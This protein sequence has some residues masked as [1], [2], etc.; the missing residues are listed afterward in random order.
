MRHFQLRDIEKLYFGYEDI[1]RALGISQNSAK[2]TAHRYVKQ[3]ML[4]RIKRN[5]YILKERWTN[6]DRE[7]KFIIA[8]ILQ[9]PSYISLTTALDYYE[10]TTQ[11]Q[12]DFIESV[13]VKRTI[14]KEI[15]QTVFNYTRISTTVYRGFLKNRGVFIAEPE[16][17]FLD[18]VYLMTLGRYSLD[19]PSIDFSKFDV[20]KIEHMAKSFSLKTQKFIA[21][22]EYFRKA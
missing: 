1:A 21:K 6:L 8:N 17:A 22:N 13:A 10:I 12:R 18:A 2:V 16:K 11:M 20:E 7:Q 3:G 15:E 4:V 5:I 19:M 9:V 14:R